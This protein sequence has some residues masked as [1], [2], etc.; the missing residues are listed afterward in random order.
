MPAAG[1]LALDA[2]E[3][4]VQAAARGVHGG[5]AVL[6][7]AERE[8]EGAVAPEIDAG[9]L[10]Q[11]ALR[12]L[13]EALRQAPVCIELGQTV[14]ALARE[15][16]RDLQ[17]GTRGVERAVHR[18]RVVA[19]RGV[20]LGNRIGADQ[21]RVP[22]GPRDVTAVGAAVPRAAATVAAQRGVEADVEP[23]VA[24]VV[25]AERLEAGA[26]QHRRPGGIGDIV[27]DDPVAAAPGCR[28][29]AA[30]ERTLVERPD[31]VGHVARLQVG[32][33]A[34]VRHDELEGL[35][36]GRVVRGEVDVA[37]HPVG[38]GEPDLRAPVAGGPD[39]VLARQVE[40][41]QR[42][43]PVA[44][45]GRQLSRLR[46]G[47]K[48]ESEGRDD[49]AREQATLQWSP[50]Q[51]EAEC[52]PVPVRRRACGRSPRASASRPR[53]ARRMPASRGSSAPG[54]GAR[55]SR[56][57]RGSGRRRRC[58]CPRERGA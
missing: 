7:E 57:P 28:G 50:S 23:V 47:G 43:R 49:R 52:T 9:G 33:R 16:V 53:R 48:R 55:R 41:R 10:D 32:E 51:N 46:R 11:V 24:R 20:R 37:E 4:L 29:D 31:R 34:P 1:V 27:G 56:G 13:R 58:A 18:H 6:P 54:R 3:A 22:A 14:A 26:H 2:R 19:V 45:D 8:L 38:N 15:A 12:G 21:Q 40:V 42:P 25:P 36:V 39:A 30:G 5:A 17:E 44:G 35:V